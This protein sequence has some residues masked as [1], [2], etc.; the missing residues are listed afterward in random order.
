VVKG[1]DLAGFMV[2]GLTVNREAA[3]STVYA[4]GQTAEE[5][6]DA[7]AAQAA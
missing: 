5:K 1:R 3:V 7:Q 2:V 4:H 6:F